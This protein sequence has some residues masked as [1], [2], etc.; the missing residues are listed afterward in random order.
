MRVC[1]G[2]VLADVSKIASVCAKSVSIN[3]QEKEEKTIE[4]VR[5]IELIYSVIREFN[6]GKHSLRLKLLIL[7]LST[8]AV[9]TTTTA[10]ARS[11]NHTENGKVWCD[12]AMR[13]RK[14]KKTNFCVK[15]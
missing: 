12:N 10:A 3:L 15:R 5:N 6:L 11:N 9:A 4:I 14:K 2:S 7:K 13:K 1:D 8:A